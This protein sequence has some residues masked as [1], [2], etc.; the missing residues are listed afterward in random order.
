[1]VT[2]TVGASPF[3]KQED[4]MKNLASAI[5]AGIAFD[6]EQ[7]AFLQTVKDDIASTF[8]AFDSTLLQ[9]IR[10]QQSD[11]TAARLGME[12]AL[13]QYL[14]NMFKSTEY[15][16]TVSDSVTSALYSATSLLSS[17]QSI[18]FEYQVQKWLGSLYSVGMSSQAVSSIANALGNLASGNISDTSSGAGKLLVMSASRAGLPYAELLTQGIN[19]SDINSLMKAMVSYLQEI[20]N[21]N[22]VV[23]S[24]YASIFGLNTA[25][26]VAARNLT[27]SIN[28]IS[29]YNLNYSGAVNQLSHMG[30]TIGER[31]SL[32]EMMSNAASNFQ[33]SIAEGIA[34][35]PAMYA[36]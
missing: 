4:L 30:R 9:I 25:D 23:Q 36:L 22:K 31:L 14:N 19:D 2:K 21:S 7:R 33:Y 26:I 35:S 24:Q 18:G 16:S 15:L 10:V 5:D 11:S 1:M 6:V 34:N 32:G 8:D 3:V 29:Q 28:N 27:G 17:Q 20:A 12:S 13:N